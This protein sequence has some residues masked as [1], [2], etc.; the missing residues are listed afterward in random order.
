MSRLFGN[1]RQNGYVVEN[2]DEALQHW[3]DV[4]GIGPFYR[5]DEIPLDYFQHHGEQSDVRLAVALGYSG[6]LQFELI[7]QLNDV[8]SP[9]RDFATTHGYG[10]HHI[11]CWSDH[12]EDDVAA[13]AAAGIGQVAHGRI[14]GGP[15]FSYFD[16]ATATGGTMMEMAEYT[17]ALSDRSAR[18][19]KIAADWD[20]SDPVRSIA[21]L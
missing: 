6:G 18:M 10:L 1:I 15:R 17:S 8:P 14:T 4:L 11:C 13:A 5:I 19:Q 9:Y 12:Y 20:G 16:T 2:L 3:T 21:S 7:E